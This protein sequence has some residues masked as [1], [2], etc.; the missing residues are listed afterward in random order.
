MRAA[1]RRWW[2]RLHRWLGLSLGLG[3]ALGAF[4]G[5]SLIVLEPLDQRLHRELFAAA[6]PDAPPAS[7]DTVRQAVVQHH[8]PQSSFTMRPPRAPGDTFWVRVSGPWHGTTYLDPATARILGRRG[9]QEGVVNFLFELHSAL[10]LGENGR[11]LLA[12]IALSYL[13]LLATGLVLWWPRNWRQAWRMRLDGGATRSLF[14]LHR[15]AGSLLGLVIAVSVASGAYLAWKP[16]A[17]F[18]TA[19]SGHAPAQPPTVA[20]VPGAAASLQ[21]MARTAQALF[22][23]AGIGYIHLAPQP[24]KPVRFR[25]KLADDPHPNGLTSVW[26]HPVTGTVLAVHRWDELDAGTRG[27]SYMYPLH[28]GELGGVAHEALN[29]LSGFTL[30]GLGVTG[31]WLWWRRRRDKASAHWS[32][33][34]GKVRA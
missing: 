34:A 11:P 14:D 32:R 27:N 15:V 3:L 13:F 33:I 29:A 4:T 1:A 25:M 7:L 30:F 19:V 5:A 6:M 21:S 12:A 22:P 28:T 23:R 17:R 18:V 2:L 31:G 8:G 26:F 20:P 16:L 10:L 24:W 9:K